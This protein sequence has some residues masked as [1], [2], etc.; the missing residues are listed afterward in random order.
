[1][2]IKIQGNATVEYA[3]STHVFV[4]SATLTE[5]PKSEMLELEVAVEQVTKLAEPRVNVVTGL[6]GTAIIGRLKGQPTWEELPG[7]DRADEK[8]LVLQAFFIDFSGGQLAKYVFNRIV[9]QH[10]F[11]HLPF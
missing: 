7:T 1:M 11:A 9:Y 10:Q 2:V 4:T 8:R 3:N 6:L 5:N